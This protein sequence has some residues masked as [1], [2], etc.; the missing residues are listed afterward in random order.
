MLTM[1]ESLEQ[2]THNTLNLLEQMGAN[3][4]LLDENSLQ[5]SIEKAEIP[6]LNKTLIMAKDSQELSEALKLDRLITSVNI[7]TPDEED[8]EQEQPEQSD[9]KINAFG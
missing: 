6:E 7:S 8:D 3:A 1:L 9:E 5:A 4:S 2:S